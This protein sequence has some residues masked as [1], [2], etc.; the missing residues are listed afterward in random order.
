[1]SSILHHITAIQVTKMSCIL[2][3]PFCDNVFKYN[4]SFS[5]MSIF[6]IRH[7]LCHLIQCNIGPLDIYVVT[8]DRQISSWSLMSLS[9]ICGVSIN[10]IYSHP[11]TNNI[12]FSLKHLSLH[13]ESI[14]VSSRR[15][16]YAII[17]QRI[18]YDTCMIFYVVFSWWVNLL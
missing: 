13:L 11:V 1:M 18:T 6:N 5:L 14:V 8:Q 4:N 12:L 15:M 17:T 9:M 2:T 3:K 10:H 7:R 16:V